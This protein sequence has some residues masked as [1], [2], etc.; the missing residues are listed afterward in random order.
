MGQH[1][2]FNES[3]MKDRIFGNESIGYNCYDELVINV[4][5]ERLLKHWVFN[6]TQ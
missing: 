1:N 3:R 4:D 6:Y 2:G 5:G